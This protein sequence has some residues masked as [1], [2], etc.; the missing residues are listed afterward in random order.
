[1]KILRNERQKLK[2]LPFFF[3]KR[4]GSSS[5]SNPLKSANE[6]KSDYSRENFGR[7]GVGEKYANRHTVYKSYKADL[8]I[9]KTLKGCSFYV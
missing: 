9:K 1:M 4:S 5:R 6:K 8:Y 7:N 3:Q 2:A